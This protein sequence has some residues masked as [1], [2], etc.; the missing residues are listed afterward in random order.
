MFWQGNKPDEQV[1][2]NALAL[3]ALR[4]TANGERKWEE[5]MPVASRLAEEIFTA[6]TDEELRELQARTEKLRT[7]ALR[8]LDEVLG[9]SPSSSPPTRFEEPLD[10]PWSLSFPLWSNRSAPRT[11]GSR[12]E[13]GPGDPC[14]KPRHPQGPKCPLDIPVVADRSSFPLALA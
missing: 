13:R 14:R 11:P 1:G 7:V 2:L 10:L 4:L 5:S 9:R 6:L 8:K 12:P 3:I